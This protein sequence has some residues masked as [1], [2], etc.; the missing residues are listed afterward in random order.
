MGQYIDVSDADFPN[1]VL[2]SSIPVLVDFWA[3]WCGPCRALAPHLDEIANQ[4]SGR[5]KVVK[6]NVDD[7]IKYAQNYGVQ[8]IPRMILFKG[9]EP[10]GDLM[11]LPR[12][13]VESLS[14]M[15]NKAL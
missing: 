13:P 1:E 9:G 15:I 7:H 5:V 11:G 14:E 2:E 6:V 12:N 10:V 4:Y 8:G 3:P